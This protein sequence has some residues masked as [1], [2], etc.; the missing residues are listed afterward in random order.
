M[1][2][3]DVYV[4]LVTETKKSVASLAK[5]A[6]SITGAIMVVK[7][8]F[9]ATKKMTEAYYI[10]EKAETKLRAA[11]SATGKSASI[12]TSKLFALAAGLQQVT[13]YGDEA[14]I[15]AMAMLQQLGDLSEKGLEDVTPAVLDF[16]SAMGINLE[17]AAT[18]VGKT[19]GSSTN[20]LSRYGL[21]IDMTGT[22]SE[23]LEAL[24]TAMTEKFGGAAIAMGETA[25]GSAEKLK[26]AWGDLGE[27]GGHLI[28]S[29][30]APMREKLTGMVQGFAE[31]LSLVNEV[32]EVLSTLG[33]VDLLA[34]V[35]PAAARIKELG[36]EIETV[37]EQLGLYKLAIK[38]GTAPALFFGD[39]IVQGELA[40]EEY[41]KKLV[42]LNKEL[43]LLS[44]TTAA[45]TADQV[46]ENEAV[47]KLAKEF[48][49]ID[50]QAAKWG[51]TIDATAEKNA[52]FGEVMADL[53]N[54]D[55]RAYGNALQRIAAIFI[56]ELNPAV[57]A[58]VKASRKLII[59]DM[60]MGTPSGFNKEEQA[61]IARGVLAAEEKLGKAQDE[62]L[63]RI[64]KLTEA[65]IGYGEA[66]GSVFSQMGADMVRSQD[67]WGSLAKAALKGI[68]AVVEGIG[69]ELLVIAA[70]NTVL[71][72]AGDVSKIPAALLAGTGAATAFTAAGA[73]GAI[74]VLGSGGIVNSP[75]LAMIG[76]RG[77]EAVVPLKGGEGLGGDTIIM[78][79]YG[80]VSSENQL[81]G[82]VANVQARK[83]RGY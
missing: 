68:A 28:D 15:S 38:A 40:V 17:T 34:L 65:Y 32:D 50:K 22:K 14:T 43:V 75:T 45:L 12:S 54:K 70:K 19:L 46:A 35:D 63:I 47:A 24:T 64:E 71:A 29:V 81:A 59:P 62:E 83:S 23:K 49:F 39:T 33:G 2:K 27:E 56:G 13:V 66:V 55:F 61:A 6:A 9:N 72:L 4:K 36:T 21:E 48:A 16:A 73:I 76:E 1:A 26:N 8:L 44:T 11:I 57:E 3:D 18:L 41:E 80:T 53:A 31:W 7:G 79:I 30:M 78:N 69:Q 25:Y 77:P 67:L 74:P 10:Q 52:F 42:A 60:G 37:T 20:A 51:D 82:F 58:A 5:Y